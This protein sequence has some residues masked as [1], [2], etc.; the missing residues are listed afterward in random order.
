MASKCPSN[1]SSSSHQSQLP[2]RPKGPAD[3]S[4]MRVY[5]ASRVLQSQ[6]FANMASRSG[7]N[8]SPH[9]PPSSLSCPGPL[10][11]MA[12][13]GPA[14]CSLVGKFPR[15]P[16]EHFTGASKCA[17][18]LHCWSRLSWYR[19]CGICRQA[20]LVAESLSY[21]VRVARVSGVSGVSQAAQFTGL[22]VVAHCP[23]SEFWR[24]TA[25]KSLSSATLCCAF[26]RLFSVL[27]LRGSHDESS[28]SR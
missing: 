8:F 28:N 9:S 17:C 14:I 10:L 16:T 4:A 26:S 12:V 25:L 19:A 2:E 20:A 22:C 11:H 21:F 7:S 1:S 23:V 24:Q 6:F 3:G 18:A 13:K 5:L 15:L 27:G